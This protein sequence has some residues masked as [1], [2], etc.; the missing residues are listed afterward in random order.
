[1]THLTF[2]YKEKRKSSCFDIS[3]KSPCYPLGVLSSTGTDI[4]PRGRSE[5]LYNPGKCGEAGTTSD[6]CTGKTKPLTF[7]LPLFLAR[8]ALK[9][10]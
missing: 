10:P 5:D 3:F 6:S 2:N 7:I 9:T 1:M 4:R 8:L